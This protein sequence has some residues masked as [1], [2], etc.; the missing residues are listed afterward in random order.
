MTKRWRVGTQVR[1]LPSRTRQS[2]PMLAQRGGVD[3]LERRD[4]DPGDAGEHAG[5]EA[6]AV[7]EQ[8]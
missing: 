3:P 8:L 2:S 1:V 6:R 5:L 4:R 7:H